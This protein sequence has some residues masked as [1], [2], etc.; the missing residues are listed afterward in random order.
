MRARS[1]RRQHR[2]RAWRR[3]C[4]AAAFAAALPAACSS[5]PEP[6]QRLPRLGDEISV[7]GQLFHTGTPVVLW[8][9]PGGYDAYRP[10]PRFARAGEE[11]TEK[12]HYSPA[13]RNL[14]PDVARR[15]AERGW[16]LEDLRKVVHLFVIHYDVAG[17]ARQC[18]KVLQDMRTLSVHFL[19]DVDGTIYQTLDLKER[20]WHA[21]SA[22]DHSVGIEIAHIGAYPAPDHE[23]LRTWYRRDERGLRVVFPKWMTE[24]GI[25][26]AGF[27]ARPARQELIHGEIHGRRYWQH[28]FTAEQYRALARLTATLSRVL[29]RVRLAAPRGPDGA[30]VRH[31]LAGPELH[32][33][34]GLVGHWHVT[35]R[36]QDPGP[37]FE[38]DRVLRSARALR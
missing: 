10:W 19:L 8:S 26:T 11:P 28:D 21:G 4:V 22:N 24:T 36:K 5:A 25:R 33:F 29:P 2:S 3:P 32:A 31:A 9:D 20:A 23:V 7:C 38:W 6:G 17:T 37:A 27:V 12:A 30:V 35:R 1:S 34:E 15:V 13:R 14:P 16:T 18:F